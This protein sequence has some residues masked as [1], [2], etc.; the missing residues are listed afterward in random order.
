MANIPSQAWKNF[1]INVCALNKMISM[2]AIYEEEGSFIS[3]DPEAN[4][5]DFMMDFKA[6]RELMYKQSPN[7]GAWYTAYFTMTKNHQLNASFDYDHKPNFKY[8]PD[9]EKFIDDL[10]VFPREERLIPAWL[11]E[12]IAS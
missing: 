2:K 4:G 5:D 11:K 1:S 6:I 10:A 3:F 12:I 8:E 9:T 7:N